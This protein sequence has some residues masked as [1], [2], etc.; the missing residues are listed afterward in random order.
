MAAERLQDQV[1]SLKAEND[2]LRKHLT[3]KMGATRLREIVTSSSLGGGENDDDVRD[4]NHN[5]DPNDRLIKWLQV[6]G[7]KV[8]VKDELRSIME[9]ASS[10]SS[11]VM[12]SSSSSSSKAPTTLLV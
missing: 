9:E 6:K 1:D 3:A 7:N 12:P 2:I 11:K 10:Q 4:G 5:D 8:A